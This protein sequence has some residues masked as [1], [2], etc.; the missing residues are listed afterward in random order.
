[1]CAKKV[2]KNQK[3]CTKSFAK[4]GKL[5]LSYETKINIF[6]FFHLCVFMHDFCDFDP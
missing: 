3:R 1:M 6:F 4:L 2:Y 5:V